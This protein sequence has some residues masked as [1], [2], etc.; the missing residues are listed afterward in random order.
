MTE[1]M[2]QRNYKVIWPEETKGLETFDLLIRPQNG[3]PE[4]ELECKSFAVDK[5]GSVKLADAHKLI[6]GIIEHLPSVIDL[7]P[8]D[9]RKTNILTI[10]MENVTASTRRGRWPPSNRTCSARMP[11]ANRR[12]SS[13]P[14]CRPPPSCSWA[15]GRAPPISKHARDRPVLQAR[16]DAPQHAM[17]QFQWS[18][19][20]YHGILHVARTIADIAQAER[21]RWQHVRE[22]VQYRRTLGER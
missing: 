2:I 9:N 15:P 8:A 5:G 10:G 21:V 13:A 7:I 3:L 19:R 17:E 11:T 16:Q 1:A 6:G 4:F 20:T 14:A 22:A 12:P 18:G